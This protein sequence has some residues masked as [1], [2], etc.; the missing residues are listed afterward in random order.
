MI[1]WDEFRKRRPRF[2]LRAHIARRRITEREELVSHFESNLGVQMPP[3][4]QLPEGLRQAAKP[5]K[6]AEPAPEPAVL[7]VAE[8]VEAQPVEAPEPE[9]DEDATDKPKTTRRRRTSRAKT[10]SASKGTDA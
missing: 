2:N 3:D 5:A 7:E 4:D 8:P 9:E 1:S 6:P 10:S